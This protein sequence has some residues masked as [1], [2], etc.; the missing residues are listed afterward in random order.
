MA[1]RF[2]SDVDVLAQHQG[3]VVMAGEPHAL[4]GELT[5]T[6]DTAERVVLRR[7]HAHVGD[8]AGEANLT[9]VLQ[10]GEHRR[11]SLRL[12]LGPHMPPGEHQG[13]VTVAGRS[14][15]AVFHVAEQ[16]ALDVAP[17]EIVVENQPGA[18]ITKRVV[19]RNAGNVPLHIGEIAPVVLDEEAGEKA[20][21]LRVRKKGAVVELRPGEVRQLDL[22]VDVPAT[23]EK[24]TRHYGS[25]ALYTADLTF[26]VVPD[27]RRPARAAAPKASTSAT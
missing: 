24:H 23:L 27:P 1:E 2:A 13:I 8:L 20:D 6:N 11:A 5:L 25:V 3:P 26:V 4:S 19:F 9:V 15:P 12:S 7:A 10:P 14:H 21:V 18:K 22:E 16:V 17:H